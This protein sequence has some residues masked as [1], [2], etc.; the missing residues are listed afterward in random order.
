MQRSNGLVLMP[1]KFYLLEYELTINLNIKLKNVIK[2][3]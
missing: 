3:F 2:Y 1:S